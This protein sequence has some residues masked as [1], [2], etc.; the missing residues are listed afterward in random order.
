MIIGQKSGIN[1]GS[2]IKEELFSLSEKGFDLPKGLESS[3][4]DASKHTK[5]V[6]RQRNNNNQDLGR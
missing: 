6:L 5:E 4:V 2:E 1:S 3:S